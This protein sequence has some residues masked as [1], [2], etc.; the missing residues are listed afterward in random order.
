MR[1]KLLVMALAAVLPAGAFAQIDETLR[2]DV[3]ESGYIHKPLRLPEK[4]SVEAF[5]LKKKVLRS[6][7]LCDMESLEGWSH[8]GLGGISLTDERSRDGSHSLRLE[9]PALP[10]KF[11]GWGIGRGVSIAYLT[12]DGQDWTPYNRLRF[13]IYPSC[14]GMRSIY[15]NLAI[16][17]DGEV[18]VPDP[19]GREGQHEINLKNNQWNDCVLEIPALPR[20]KVTDLHFWLEVFGKDLT[21]GDTVRVDID[22]VRLETVENPEVAKGWQPGENRIVLSGTGYTTL[23]QKT[24]VVNIPGDPEKFELR[25]CLTARTVH[26]GK[27]KRVHTET[28]EFQTLDFSDFK[29]P[30]RYFISIGDVTSASF[31]IDDNVWDDSAWRMIN[32]MFCERCGYPVPGKHGTCHSDLHGEYDGREFQLHGGWHDAGDMAQ[33][34]LQTG[35]ISYGF[36]QMAQTARRKGEK[37]LYN[38]L[39]EEAMWGI[40]FVLRSRIA[41]GYRVN[42]WTTNLWTDGLLYTDDDKAGRRLL[43]VNDG[44][45]ENFVLA[46]IEA[47]TAM[48]LKDDPEMVVKL[49]KSAIE[50][51]D[52]ARARYDKYGYQ[53]LQMIRTGHAKNTPE[54]QY[55]ASVSWAASMLYRLTGDKKY[56][57]EAVHFIQLP[58]QCQC[59]EPVGGGLNGFFYG[60]AQHLSGVHYSHKSRDYAF[61]EALEALCKTQPDHPD[62]SKWMNSIELY[63]GF[64][65]AVM[66]YVEPYGMAPSGVYNIHEVEYPELFYPWQLGARKETAASEYYAQLA[67]GVKLDDEYY[68]RRFP[69]WYSFR[70]NTVVSLST[71]KAAAIC[72]RVLGDRSLKD[73]AEKQ[74]SWVVGFNPFG[75]SIIYGEGTFWGQ[76]YNA[77]PGEMTGEIPVGFQSYGNEDEPYWPQFNNATYKEV[78]GLTASRWLMLISE[79]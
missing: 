57:E 68:L 41:D 46:G 28:G 18:K 23:T 51:F 25:D 58:L 63:A 35:E 9:A 61:M 17:N 32:F 22:N 20:D 60:D 71:G 75:Q 76:Q 73:I 21:M 56:A 30:G 45:Y 52:F 48:V 54:S 53:E 38:R 29:T 49:R 31:R 47:Y 6:D 5:N 15:V 62:F 10:E 74:L 3:I 27:I 43:D 79:F 72:A 24:A 77:L 26:T 69:V 33:Q 44:A 70:G 55:N 14:E 13:S 11:L 34:T 7:V 50:D 42:A 2:A 40:D 36:L 12:L 65:K 78:F 4:Q 8:K 16:T 59:T 66:K 39:M 19:Y 67:S 1:K 64:L 37:D